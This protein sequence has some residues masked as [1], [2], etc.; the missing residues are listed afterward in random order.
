MDTLSPEERSRR[1]GLV[2][3]S[4]NKATEGRLAA[5]FRKHHITG[6]RRNYKLPG[7]PDFVFPKSRVAL[8][9]DGCFWHGCS[10][11]GRIPKSKTDWW[12]EKIQRTAA[13]DKVIVRQLI[14]DRWKAIRIWEHELALR[15]EGKLL[16]K[17]ARSLRKTTKP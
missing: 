2:K 6:W 10:K 17:I 15:H 13:R 9:V 12:K 5:L 3:S 8:F 11:H 14:A 1:M 16:A 7:K 4:G